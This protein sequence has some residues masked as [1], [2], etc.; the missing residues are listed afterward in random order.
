MKIRTQL[1][2]T[3]AVFGVILLVIASATIAADEHGAKV[4]DQEKIAISIT[5]D[6][7]ELGYLAN[8][9]V[10]YH[11]SQQLERW[12]SKYASFSTNVTQLKV[13]DLEQQAIVNNI[14][15]DQQRMKDVFD[16]ITSSV[17]N[18]S[19]NQTLASIQVS[20]SRMGIQ[21][22]ELVSESMRLSQLLRADADQQKQTTNILILFLVGVFGAFLV[23][24]Y[25]Q[26][27]RRTL[28][29]ID[30]LK[31]GT[32]VIGSGNLDFKIEAKHN[33]EI[34]D[35]TRA[36]NQMSTDL[37]SVTT[38]KTE[39]E[40]EVAERKLTEEELEK[41]TR[42]LSRSNDELKQFAYVASH[43]LQEPLRMVTA[44]LTR[45][46]SN[47]GDKL[48]DKGK[49]YLGF[50]VEGGLR[51]RNLVQDL[52]TFSRIDAQ[53][54]PFKETSMDAV[55][56]LVTTNLALQIKEQRAMV[57]HGPLPVVIADDGQMVQLLQNLVSNA[58][59]FR[60]EEDPQI[61]V[62]YKKEGTDWEFTV[63]DN[64]IGLDQHY[65]DKIFVIFQR[66]HTKE[67]YPGSGIG[68]AISKKIVER[69][70]GRIWVESELGKGSSFH[71][72]I[73]AEGSK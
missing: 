36:F 35:L 5:Q 2:I 69:H 72:T 28:R 22:N 41:R 3:A 33:D 32:T 52:L 31:K 51:A 63:Q 42:E 12:Q 8:D 70:G 1:I 55:M 71:F 37:K 54:K 64:G 26:T 48:D 27:F 23:A 65:A 15:V 53:G 62:E 43:D 16:N 68:L 38:S 7:S 56:D 20:W 60:K 73:P 39:L 50:A 11:E 45:L 21:S 44:Y 66:L 17:A 6:A 9:Y 25:V 58:I 46:E 61:R 59:K 47:C 24:V 29:S 13:D 49:I 67:E 30:D 40:R 10:I 4:G 18:S 14:Q 19:A 57:T 34:G